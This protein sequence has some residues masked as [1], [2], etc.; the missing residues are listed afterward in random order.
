MIILIKPNQN[1]LETMQ[2]IEQRNATDCESVALQGT[3]KTFMVNSNYHNSYS[4][5]NKNDYVLTGRRL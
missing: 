4:G 5:R 2:G 1:R 3:A